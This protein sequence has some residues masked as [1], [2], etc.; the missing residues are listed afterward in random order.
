M[1]RTGFDQVIGKEN[2]FRST[3]ASIEAVQARV[4]KDRAREQENPQE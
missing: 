2:I 4:A 1:Q 3:D